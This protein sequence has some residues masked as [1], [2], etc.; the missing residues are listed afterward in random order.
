MPK[1][2]FNVVRLTR[3]LVKNGFLKSEPEEMN[4]L[5]RYPPHVPSGAFAESID[6]KKLPYL[7][8]YNQAMERCVDFLCL[9]L[10]NFFRKYSR[11]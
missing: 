8:Y 2:P 5:R 1:K 4:F 9:P 3:I 7:K 6:P 11:N 10:L